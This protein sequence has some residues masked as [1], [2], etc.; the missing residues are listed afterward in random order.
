MAERILI[1]GGAGFIGFALAEAAVA[2][3]MDVTILDNFARGRQDAA[4]IALR[5]HVHVVDHDLTQPIPDQLLGR[6]YA[7]VY[8]LAA[9]VGVAQSATSPHT[10]LRT[11]VQSVIHMLDWCQ[12]VRPT[13]IFFSSTSEVADGAVRVG[14][15]DLP[16]GED[17]PLVIDAP[18]RPR[19]A[20]AIS[21]ITGEMLCLH[22]ARAYGLR[23]RIGRYH[24]IYGPR[25]GYD[26]VIPQLVVRA[27]E[28][29]DPFTV[30]GPRQYR[31]F[32]YIDDAVRATL[33]LTALD[34]EEP[35]LVN[36]GNDQEMIQI[37]EL[38]QLILS[39]AGFCPEIAEVAAP[40]GSPDRRCPDISR[41][42]MLT[43]SHP[44][45][46]LSQGLRQTFAWYQAAWQQ[47]IGDA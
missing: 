27:L 12:R 20:Y 31:A 19:S 35:L 17:L 43:G 26:H 34:T 11:N 41:L 33:V 10:V 39:L 44:L 4:F 32:C 42:T 28:R 47:R 7:A 13:A 5:K 37:A 14:L 1:T 6:D 38:A 29:H 22:Y 2:R 25:M 15:A 18:Q 45:V 36:I 3:G 16:T 24:N 30:Y 40:A 46:P 8:H 23:V 9:M 21:K